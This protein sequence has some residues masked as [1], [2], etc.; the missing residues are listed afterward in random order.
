MKQSGRILGV[1]LVVVGLLAVLGI[2]LVGSY[3]SFVQ[4]S[5]Q[6]DSQFANLE[7]RLQRRFDLIPNLV[8]TVKGHMAHEQEVFSNIAEARARMA[9]ARTV[10]ERVGATNQLEGALGRLLVVMEN[11]PLLKAQESVSRLM[12]ELAGTE[13]RITVERDNFNAVV[14]QYNTRI[15]SFPAVILANMFG[16]EARAYFQ[17]DP[18]AQQAPRVTFP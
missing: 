15:K 17:A 11:Y 6:V 18:G 1:L 14:Q 16:Y 5:Q 10:D 3:N 13:N 12:D 9:G 7:A 8:E 4:L 2:F